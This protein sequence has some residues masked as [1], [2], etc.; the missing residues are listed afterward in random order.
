MDA[1]LLIQ[2]L[3]AAV[4]CGAMVTWQRLAQGFLTKAAPVSSPLPDLAGVLTSLA[5]LRSG[6]F[7]LLNLLSLTDSPRQETVLTES[8]PSMSQSFAA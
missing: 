2:L 5:G 1:W 8:A 7:T 4:W 6:S 3:A